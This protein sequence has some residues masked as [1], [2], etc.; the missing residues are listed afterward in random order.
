M[1]DGWHVFLYKK[2]S[3]QLPICFQPQVETINHQQWVKQLKICLK[4]QIS[5]YH[6]LNQW[7]LGVTNGNQGH[8]VV[9]LHAPMCTSAHLHTRF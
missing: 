9:H 3:I 2:L 5:Y 8:T 4:H 1:P 6:T 7:L